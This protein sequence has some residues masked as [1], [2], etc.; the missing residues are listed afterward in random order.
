MV[1]MV[2]YKT[3]LSLVLL[4]WPRALCFTRHLSVCLP[5]CLSVSIFT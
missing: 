5:V 4:H 1:I 2:N 3:L